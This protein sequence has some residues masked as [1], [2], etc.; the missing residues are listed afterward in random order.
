MFTW[1]ENLEQ[2]EILAG[3]EQMF[4]NRLFLEQSGPKQIDLRIDGVQVTFFANNWEALKNRHP[5][6][7]HLFIADLDL[8][9]GM[10]L[11]TLFLRAKFR[12]YYDLYTLH[13]ARYSIS[14]MYAIIE[15]LM[16]GMNERLFQMALVYTDD[17]IDDKIDHLQPAH[18][19]SKE[20]ISK[21]FE[22]H[23]RDWIKDKG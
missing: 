2:A 7:Q 20:G 13:K 22:K 23:I 12:D 14:K 15:G 8:L 9:T 21:Y 1:E 6:H 3:L 18:K 11:N 17:I 5:L 16:S 10:K 4:P 19:I